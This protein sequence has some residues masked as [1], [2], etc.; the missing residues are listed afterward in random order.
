M[1]FINLEVQ[2]RAF[3]LHCEFWGAVLAKLSNRMPLSVR[4]KKAS[5]GWRLRLK[6]NGAS[7]VE[8][9][10]RPWNT[11][12]HNWSIASHL[13]CM[14]CS[15][16]IKVDRRGFAECS[17]PT[18]CLQPLCCYRDVLC[19]I[20]SAHSRK[21]LAHKPSFAVGKRISR[22]AASGMVSIRNEP[23]PMHSRCLPFQ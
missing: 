9:W 4:S 22:D 1:S 23:R 13:F 2:I 7:F 20:L 10:I 11:Y 3:D 5:D 15:T 12:A 18:V 16:V 19:G 8:L 6:L 14:S 21:E 17:N